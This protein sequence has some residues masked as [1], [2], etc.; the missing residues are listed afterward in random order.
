MA[1][2]GQ[3]GQLATAQLRE[4]VDELSSHVEEDAPD[5]AEIVRLADAVGELADQVAE[6]YRNIDQTLERHLQAP[7]GSEAEDGGS[8]QQTEEEPQR[9]RR[10]QPSQR[11]GGTAEEVTKEELLERAREVDVQGRSSMTKDELA[12]AVEAEESVSKEELL[13]RA[14]EAGIEGRSSMSKNELR[15]ALREAGA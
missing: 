15:R 5:L 2:L 9:E 8:Q 14:R 4:G 13:E 11:N 10:E 12:Q 3:L 6:I 1:T 7:S